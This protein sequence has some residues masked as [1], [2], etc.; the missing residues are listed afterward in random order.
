SSWTALLAYVRVAIQHESREQFRVLFLDRKNQLLADEV[1][2]RGTI[3]HAPAY[4]RE[5]VRRAIELSASAVIL[6]HNHPSGDP[7]P[8]V[9]DIEMTKQIVEAARSLKITIHD[10]LVVRREAVAIFRAPSPMEEAIMTIEPV[11]AEARLDG[12]G[13]PAFG[14]VNDQ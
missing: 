3:D 14:I 4:P 2:N 13:A 5:V 12:P 11:R 6:V 1:M 7:T 8:S 9:A 10:H